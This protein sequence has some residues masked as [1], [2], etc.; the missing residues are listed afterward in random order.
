MISEISFSTWNINGIHNKVLGDK[1]KNRD[2]VD[3]ISNTDFMFLTETWNDQNLYI[4]GFET[5]NSIIVQSKS[6]TACR[7]SGG[8]SLI[9]KS[10]FKNHVTIVKNTKNFLWSKSPRKY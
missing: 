8:I 6:K 7:K 2:F 3:A 1:S 5:I 9:F 10:K 4:P